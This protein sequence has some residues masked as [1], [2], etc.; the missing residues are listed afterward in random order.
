MHQPARITGPVSP[1]A[2]SVV[3]HQSPNSPAPPSKLH[4]EILNTAGL[5]IQ[6]LDSMRSDPALQDINLAFPQIVVTGSESVGKSTLLERIAM[7]N[8]FPRDA[9]MCTR[10]PIRL[11]LRHLSLLELEKFCSTHSPPLPYSPGLVYTRVTAGEYDSGIVQLVDDFDKIMRQLMDTRV[12]KQ[13]KGTV[14]GIIEEEAV[15]EITGYAVPNLQLV[16]LPGIVCGRHANEPD[17]IEQQ[18]RRLAEKYISQP[19]TMVLAVIP[20]SERIRNAPVVGLVQKHKKE[21]HTLIVLTMC[22]RA[23][24]PEHDRFADLRSRIDGSADDCIPCSQVVRFLKLHQNI[25]STSIYTINT[26]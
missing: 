22:D 25:T 16:D 2:R 8:L 17:D 3:I 18:T 10:M 11:Q 20:A 26:R 5:L 23:N 7:R 6:A 19:H 1:Q 4:E 15:I 24:G 21:A 9:R 13:K 12:A 14:N